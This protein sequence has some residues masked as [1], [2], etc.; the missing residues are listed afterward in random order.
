MVCTFPSVSI[1]ALEPGA[2]LILQRGGNRR[3]M[4]VESLRTVNG[5]DLIKFKGV[6]SIGDAYQLVGCSIFGEDGVI[7]ENPGEETP[8][9]IGW[10]LFDG[11]GDSVGEI[12]DLID[13]TLQ[14]LLVVRDGNGAKHLVPL[15]DEWVVE[16]DSPGQ[17]LVMSL[18][19]GLI[20]IN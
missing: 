2:K 18:P 9:F 12:V 17:R 15:V 1:G 14:P 5:S 13:R 6:D 8:E 4:E 11:E 10:T 3:Q 7:V 16:T 20:G 19:E